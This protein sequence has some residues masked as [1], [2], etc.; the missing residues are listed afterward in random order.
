MPEYSI[1]QPDVD[2]MFETADAALLIGDIALKY[3]TTND[4]YHYDLG[5]EWKKLMGEDGICVLGGDR[6]SADKE[7]RIV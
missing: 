3:S 4:F 2:R 6:H 5:T 1:C 7:K